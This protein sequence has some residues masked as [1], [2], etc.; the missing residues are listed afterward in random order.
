[1][2]NSQHYRQTASTLRRQTNPYTCL[3]LELEESYPETLWPS[4]SQSYGLSLQG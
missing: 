2:R 3:I 1:M 4:R